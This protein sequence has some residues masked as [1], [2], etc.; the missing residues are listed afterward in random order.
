MAELKHFDIKTWDDNIKGWKLQRLEDHELIFDQDEIEID[1]WLEDKQ[2]AVKLEI[3][4][5]N[6]NKQLLREILSVSD[7]RVKTKQTDH[8]GRFNLGVDYAEKELE[9]LVHDVREKTE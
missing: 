2:D 8:R 1:L 6:S 9:I 7:E 3:P 4:L 5:N